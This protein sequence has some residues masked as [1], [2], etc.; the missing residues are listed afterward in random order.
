MAVVKCARCG[1]PFVVRGKPAKGACCTDCASEEATSKQSLPARRHRRAA[2][3][4]YYSKAGVIASG[5][6]ILGGVL[7]FLR[8]GRSLSDEAAALLSWILPLAS[9][10]VLLIRSLLPE[11]TLIH[12]GLVL[13]G[14]S[15]VTI[16]IVML[17]L[18]GW[19]GQPVALLPALVIGVPCLIGAFW[20]APGSS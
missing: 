6:L 9:G 20:T 3:W 7:A 1:K 16:A 19:P 8:Q 2:F 17:A 5:L 14:T 18:Y 11:L 13:L 4:R 15:F 12:V 10:V